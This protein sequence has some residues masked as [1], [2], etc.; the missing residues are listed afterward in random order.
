MI[1][2]FYFF[3]PGY[4]LKQLFWQCVLHF[5]FS[6]NRQGK[7][8]VHLVDHLHQ[9]VRV[10]LVDPLVQVV[11]LGMNIVL[12]HSFHMGDRNGYLVLVLK[13]MIEFLL[14]LFH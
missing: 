2:S 3:Y 12:L 11:R 1:L 7:H 9:T 8:R 10:A 4:N 6:C 5:L 14:T 13:F